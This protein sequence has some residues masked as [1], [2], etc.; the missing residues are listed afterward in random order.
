MEHAHEHR[1]EE[2]LE[3]D[4]EDHRLGQAEETAADA[5]QSEAGQNKVQSGVL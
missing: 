5:S 4:D 3:E 1:Q 2:H